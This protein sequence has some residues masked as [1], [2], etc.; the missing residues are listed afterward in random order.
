MSQ[1]FIHDHIAYK[2]GREKRESKVEKK[3]DKKIRFF[4]SE[5]KKRDLFPFL[6]TLKNIASSDTEKTMFF[7]PWQTFAHNY[8]ISFLLLRGERKKRYIKRV[9]LPLSLSLRLVL[10]VSHIRGLCFPTFVVNQI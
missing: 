6:L 3:F 7:T 5:N 4:P 1:G 9:I 8:E 2:R 10:C